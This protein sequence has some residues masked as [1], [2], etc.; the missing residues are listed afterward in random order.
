MAVFKKKRAVSGPSA[1]LG[2]EMVKFCRNFCSCA[3]DLEMAVFHGKRDHLPFEG[4]NGILPEFLLLCRR[5]KMAVF[6]RE[7]SISGPSALLGPEMMKFCRNFCSC[8][9]D[10]KWPF[11]RG[12][13]SEKA[14][15]RSGRSFKTS[16]NGL[17]EASKCPETVCERLENFQKWLKMIRF[18]LG[19]KEKSQNLSGREH[20]MLRISLGEAR[21]RSELVWAEC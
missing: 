8:A 5:P 1:L 15:K 16:R 18:G 10:Q 14:Q 13:G 2:P 19:Q 6:K 4:R 17:G 7:R 21:K 20:K 11:L 3:V 9:V 12:N